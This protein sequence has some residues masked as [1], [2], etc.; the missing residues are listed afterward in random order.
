M[1]K[2]HQHAVERSGER[3]ATGLDVVETVE[4][5]EVLPAKHGRTGFRR[6]FLSISSF[7]NQHLTCPVDSVTR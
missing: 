7:A 1:V 6:N 2:L 4:T 5:G 3:G